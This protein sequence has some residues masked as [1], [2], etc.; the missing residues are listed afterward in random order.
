MYIIEIQSGDVFLINGKAFVQG[1]Q[2]LKFLGLIDPDTGWLS[3]LV[4]AGIFFSGEKTKRGTL[5]EPKLL[6]RRGLLVNIAKDKKNIDGS[7]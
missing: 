6:T 2:T 4:F 3:S 1:R 5:F 7:N